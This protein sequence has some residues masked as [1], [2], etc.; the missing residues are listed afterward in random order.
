[1]WAWA[2]ANPGYFTLVVIIALCV[3]AAIVEEI[4]KK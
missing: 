2:S 1:M 3:V 4:R